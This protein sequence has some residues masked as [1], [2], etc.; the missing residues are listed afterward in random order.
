MKSDEPVKILLVDDRPEG[1]IAMEAVLKN[2]AYTLVTAF[3]GREALSTLADNDFAVILLDVQM[4]DLDG[5]ETAAL[6]KNNAAGAHVPIIFITAINK[7]VAHV[8][9]GYTSG[10]VDYIFK[11]FNPEI[12]R[13]KVSIF[14]DLYRMRAKLQ[15]Q[16]DLLIEGERRDREY[17]I[18]QIELKNLHRY[19][20][21]A[22]AIPHLVWKTAADGTMQYL[23]RFWCRYTGLTE[24]Q[25][26]GQGWHEVFH[27]E[28]VGRFLE[29]WSAS[30]PTG[31]SFEVECRIRRM[32]GAE[33]WHLIR[34]VAEKETSGEI[35]S[36]IGTCTDIHELKQV[37]ASLAS[38]NETLE[39]KVGE[40]TQELHETN[41][42]LQLAHKEIV[43]ISEKERSRLGQDLHDGLA[44]E[45]TGACFMIQSVRQD[46]HNLPAR[47][48]KVI[49]S[50]FQ[51]MKNALENCRRLAR[52]LYPIELEQYGL[53]MALAELAMNTSK[54]YQVRC[55]FSFEG[56]E[57]TG[58][59][60]I[61]K[62]Q[63]YRI[64]Q[65][66]VQ[67]ATRHSQSKTINILLS[68]MEDRLV[69]QVQDDG[70]GIPEDKKNG[71]GFRIMHN[72][73]RMIGATLSFESRSGHG[74]C[75][76]CIWQHS[77]FP[78]VPQTNAF[79]AAAKSQVVAVDH[80]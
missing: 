58:G 14:A 40:R 25:S 13:A 32:D 64:V 35:N 70:I 49:G 53:S 51:M 71:M 1:L 75:V 37:S 80:T 30:R 23:N 2:S 45:L 8:H 76:R 36:W 57:T 55:K 10:A 65:E 7:E 41:L 3:S 22:D 21:L 15:E 38:I 43:E 17:R 73:A 12:L 42:A 62:T 24:E 69:L 11:P 27:A 4:P 60:E 72:R 54:I 44:Q 77:Q 48:E 9:R 16:S 61:V 19:R 67:N 5:F 20:A 47:V 18:A 39:A 46:S 63:L 28:D 74:T 26:K 78:Q 31:E 56:P 29:S 59:D 79:G 6:I 33:R 52:N 66:A 50:A 68:N 34:V